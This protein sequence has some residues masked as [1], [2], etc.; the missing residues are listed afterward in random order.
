MPTKYGYVR[1]STAD[2]HED[3]QIIAL[4]ALDIHPDNIFTDKQSGKDFN[5]PQYRKLLEIVK[6]GDI[7]Y[8][9]SIDRL[10]RNYEEIQSQWRIL[11]KELGVDIAVL[12]MA[13]LDTRQHK[14]LLGT[15][16]S[17]VIL[18]VLS[19]VA[20]SQRQSMLSAQ[21]AG[22]KAAR[23]RGVR[24]GRPIKKPPENFTVLVKHWEHGEL[25]INDLLTRTGLTAS[26]F[27]RRLRE[28][29]LSRGKK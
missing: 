14:D 23:A 21:A 11:T 17:D 1:V 4:S 22:I 29:R 12:D 20:D 10:G 18:Q 19:F 28:L 9:Q 16:I 24:F 26:T 8:I 2:Q 6:P 25:H 5:R 15:F 7:L 3:R 27:Y 13:L